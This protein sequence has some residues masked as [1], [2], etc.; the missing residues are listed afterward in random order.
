ADADIIEY[1]PYELAGYK[2]DGM[3]KYYISWIIQDVDKERI[4]FVEYLV[5]GIIDLFYYN[6]SRG[7]HYLIQKNDRSLVELTNESEVKKNLETGKWYKVETNE[8]VGLLKIAMS[9]APEL[10]DKI[11]K[12]QLSYKSLVRIAEDY[13]NLKC[14]TACLVY[15]KGRD[16]LIWNFAVLGGINLSRLDFFHTPVNY[17]DG[18]GFSPGSL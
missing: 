13:H 12:A 17:R 8:H 2:F 1:R 9:D 4:Q 6:D 18:F 7:D 5:D 14:D 11:N 15:E 16:R 3:D 10:F